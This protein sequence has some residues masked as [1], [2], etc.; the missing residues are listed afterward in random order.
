MADV[1]D[2]A[3]IARLEELALALVSAEQA[4]RQGRSKRDFADL[5]RMF[6]QRPPPGVGFTGEMLDILVRKKSAKKALKEFG[7]QAG[8]AA[9]EPLTFEGGWRTTCLPNAMDVFERD[10][11]QLVLRDRVPD[12]VL[13]ALVQVRTRAALQKI[14]VAFVQKQDA[15]CAALLAW[16]FAL[17]DLIEYARRVGF[18][19]WPASGCR[20]PFGLGNSVVAGAPGAQQSRLRQ[21]EASEPPAA[22]EDVA[23]I[24][25]EDAA[26]VE[27]V[28]AASEGVVAA[29][30]AGAAAAG[31]VAQEMNALRSR[32]VQAEERLWTSAGLHRARDFREVASFKKP[33]RGIEC[34]AEALRI[35][36][37]HDV[38]DRAGFSGGPKWAVQIRDFQRQTMP[39][40]VLHRLVA[41]E[42]AVVL[43]ALR[44]GSVQRQL[45]E[46]RDEAQAQY[47]RELVQSGELRNSVEWSVKRLT[48]QSGACAG[49]TE[50]ILAVHDYM[51][52][53]QK[54]GIDLWADESAHRIPYTWTS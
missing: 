32:V 43:D 6:T 9:D 15:G 7:G 34:T 42:D 40:D 13:D 5:K 39:Q 33:A 47:E 14:D 49:I 36:T 3:T 28:A 52:A 16:I 44:T 1:P 54:H 35:L 31:S 24:E 41:P 18:D 29:E 20:I 48:K 10:V 53:A 38:N 11:P 37:Q 12:E 23:A 17:V 22:A 25:Q 19:L 21:K 50:W 51:E 30:S 4:L 26:A 2:E 45:R 27:D 8:G 46:L